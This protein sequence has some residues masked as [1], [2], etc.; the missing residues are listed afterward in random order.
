MLAVR[1]MKG[2]NPIDALWEG[3]TIVVASRKEEFDPSESR[4]VENPGH[5]SESKRPG[6][7]F[8][9]CYPFVVLVAYTVEYPGTICVD[10][11]E[12]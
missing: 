11:Q 7:K 5:A 2:L 6:S 9:E 1:V 8:V 12:E 3:R 4:E 10:P